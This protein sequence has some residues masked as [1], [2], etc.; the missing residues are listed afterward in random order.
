M[1]KWQRYGLAWVLPA[2]LVSL[3]AAL[4]L[5][6]CD[7]GQIL[8]NKGWG[9]QLYANTW[10]H[11]VH[12]DLF[13]DPQYAPGEEFIVGPDKF[14]TYF[15][16]MPALLRGFVSLWF[17]HIY[18][19]NL[20]NLSMICAA[21]LA[22]GSVWYA[23]RRLARGVRTPLTIGASIVMGIILASPLSYLLVWRWTYHEVILWGLAWALLFTS[24]YALWIFDT[25]R[26]NR[27]HGVLMGLAVGMAMMSR[28]TIGL[29]LV[30]PFAYLCIR[31]F[32]QSIRKKDQ[33]QLRLLWPGM[34]VCGALAVGVMTV[35]YMRWGSPFSFV[36]IDQNIQFVQYY[37]E[38]GG[39]IRKAG[40][41]NI[42]RLPYSL[43]YYLVP[44]DGNFQT[45]P[46]FV[47][48]D[49]ELNVMNSAPHYDYIEGS[50]VPIVMSMVYLLVLSTLGVCSLRK[51]KRDERIASI[52]LLGGALLTFGAL[53][54]VY[55]TSM[56]YTAEFI[57]PVVFLSLVYIAAL[58]HG[59]VAPPRR[60]AKIAL[61]MIGC[62][63]IYMTLATTLGYKQF[64][65]GMP[66]DARASVQRIIQYTP[67]DRDTKHIING[68][69]HPVY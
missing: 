2:C 54:T 16:I 49:R 7:L 28:P 45:R 25:R 3:Y 29:T 11:I 26:V 15:G 13:I 62:L 63:S 57:P 17:T 5:T 65:W 14:V 51:F 53:L 66:A 58:Q 20:A 27:W 68:K 67:T 38:R 44:S 10:D 59:L 55:A 69:R 52:F 32:L 42:N 21:L 56:R 37:P 22:L 60:K 23:A 36:R 46:P 48:I 18:N 6:N 35:N 47:T 12:G 61:A 24:I 4:M 9:S 30:L 39:A 19:Y 64:V 40:E 50:R 8:S 31:A 33:Q 41:F 43:Y 1:T 34:L